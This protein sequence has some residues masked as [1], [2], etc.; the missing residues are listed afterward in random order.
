M[1]ENYVVNYDINVRSQAAIQALN[2]FQQATNKLQQAGKQLTAFQKKI[3]AVTNKLNQMSRKAPVL[4]IATSKVNKK[5]DATIAKLEKI[6]RLAKK[7]AALNVTT[8]P[9]P[10]GNSRTSGSRSS[11]TTV[12]RP[13]PAPAVIPSPKRSLNSYQALGHTMIDTGGI[14]ALDFVKGMGIA[15]GI[16]GLGSLIGTTIKEAT[17]YDNLM[18]T[19]RNI[20]GTHD[21][22][23]DTFAQR[24]SQMEHIVRDVGVKTKFTAPQVADAAKF[25]AMAGF[26][27]E[28]INKS[29]A[30]IADIA[31]VGDTDLGETAD[32]V[33]NIM[34][35]YG[36]D[37]S[38][39]RRAADIMTMTF[40]KS[41]TTLLEI[42]EAYKY[43]AS[44]LSAGGVSFEEAT[45][46]MGI[47]GDAGIKGSQA[48]TTLRTIMANIVNP[49]KKQLTNWERIGVSRTDENGRVRPLTEIFQDLKNADLYVDDFYKLFHKTAAQGAVSLAQNV[50]KW[51]EIVSVNF[52]SD[53]IVGKLADEKK[54]TIQ[55]LWYQMTSAFT[56]TGMQVFEE[57]NSPIRELITSVTS[58]LK[59]DD[60]KKALREMATLTMEIVTFLKDFALT[61]L[62]IYQRFSGFIKL[63]LVWQVK[64]SS[65]LVPLRIFKSLFDFGTWI[66]RSIQYIGSLSMQ[67]GMLSKNIQS[68]NAAQRVFGSNALLNIVARSRGYSPAVVERFNRMYPGRGSIGSYVA[69]GAGI[70]GAVGGAYLGSML[71][72]EGSGLSALGT[73]GGSILGGWGS[74]K[75]VGLLPKLWPLI[76]NPVGAVVGIVGA[77]GAAGY[78]WYKYQK[79]ID[80]ATAANERFLGSTSNLNGI[81]YSEHA[82]MA[83]KYL[84][85]VYNKQLDV[86]DAISAHVEL[87]KEQLGLMKT[88]EDEVNKDPFSKTHKAIFD[89]AN[90]AFGFWASEDDAR[91]AVFGSIYRPDGS[92]DAEM[93]VRSME[94]LDRYGNAFTTYS[95]NGVGFGRGNQRTYEAIAAARL[96]YGL[97][98]D[99]SEGTELS[100]T[101]AD[102][103]NRFLKASSIEDFNAVISQLNAFKQN[104]HDNIIPGSAG[105]S[106]STIGSNSFAENQRGYHYVTAFN[107]TLGEQFAW[108][109]PQ[110]AAANLMAT[111]VKVLQSHDTNKTISDELAKTFLLQSGIDI[112]NAKRY[113]EFGSDKFMENFGFKNGQWGSITANIDGKDVKLTAEQ[114]RQTFLSFHERIIDTVNKLSPSIRPYFES[115][116]NNQIWSYGDPTKQQTKDGSTVTLDGV[117]YT[118]KNG[119]WVPDNVVM[120]PMSDAD[121]QKKLVAQN[122]GTPTQPTIT[123]GSKSSDYKSHYNNNSAAPKQVIVK[124]E[125][126]MNVES[127]D[128]SNP[129]NAAVIADLKGQLTQA[130]VDVVHDF[131]ETYHG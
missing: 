126:L 98:R 124:I 37:P 73:I 4:D 129:D 77:I 67:F 40:T 32:V 14:G 112:F 102:F 106:M 21:R 9:A 30:P 121:M 78:A 65:I 72:E 109:N 61:I 120:L 60:A 7:T 52:L 2:S 117:K 49:T 23:K 75:L 55:G 13:K 66:G 79:A 38:Q 64:L 8:G 113:G 53:G 26:D 89:N 99:T 29:I 96:L 110:T 101:I 10:A 97:G 1:A 11:G 63:W 36:I 28:A 119:Q 88:A 94:N 47:L 116:I 81:N 100:K 87:M 57:M 19:A 33:T 54:N 90:K 59:T 18:A 48:G 85:I 92:L 44:L 31:L 45:A 25:L 103:Q 5:L 74:M 51:N 24:F 80:E 105:W 68:A 104:K 108:T 131:D 58:W 118:F 42:A 27:V 123:G 91:T 12:A 82:T 115:Y 83:D 95:Y 20:L 3:E 107:N 6:H 122:N 43:S 128:L 15:Y 71:G 56:E 111:W 17:E 46:A 22:D 34:T 50:D 70:A 35:G 130:L 39:V 76:A 16:T 62:D 93:I 69:G 125:N 41:N 84:A 127:V 86:N 114:A